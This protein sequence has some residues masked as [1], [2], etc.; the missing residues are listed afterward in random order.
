MGEQEQIIAMGK[1]VTR[2]RGL[3]GRMAD[4]ESQARGFASD[5]E[6][7]AQ[8]LKAP[9]RADPN[10]SIPDLAKIRE[11]LTDMHDTAQQLGVERANLVN[12]GVEP[13]D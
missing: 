10:L 11:V 8:A 1:T 3:K 5:L 7:V 12:F 6:R 2:Y 13:K 9:L 4:L